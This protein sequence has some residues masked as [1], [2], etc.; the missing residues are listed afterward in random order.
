ML[1]A[2]HEVPGKC[3]SEDPSRRARY[4][5]RFRMW[6]R[7]TGLKSPSCEKTNL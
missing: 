3:G 4:D 1:V 6:R 5:E 2:W 7:I